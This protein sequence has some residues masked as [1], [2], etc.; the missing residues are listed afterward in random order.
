MRHLLENCSG[1]GWIL[2]LDRGMRAARPYISLRLATRC[3]RKSVAAA[4]ATVAQH[5]LAL[6]L[7]QDGAAAAAGMARRRVWVVR[8]VVVAML[9]LGALAAAAGMARLVVLWHPFRC[10]V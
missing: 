8:V 3:L 5:I 1:Q 4:L 2:P 7:R 10:G 6:T 9:L